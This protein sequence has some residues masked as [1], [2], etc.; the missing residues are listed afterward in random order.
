LHCL[1]LKCFRKRPGFLFIVEYRNVISGVVRAIQPI[2]VC[3]VRSCSFYRPIAVSASAP[4]GGYFPALNRTPNDWPAGRTS[5]PE[6]FRPPLDGQQQTY[7]EKNQEDEYAVQRLVQQAIPSKSEP[8]L[9]LTGSSNQGVR[10]QSSVHACHR[11]IVREDQSRA[12]HWSGA[13][14]RV[15]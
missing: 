12:P 6:P 10:L 2:R 11:Q 5:A 8:F 7:D 3:K 14:G 9:I 15:S 4:E 13:T 1:S